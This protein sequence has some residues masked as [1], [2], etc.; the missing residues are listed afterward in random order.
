[1]RIGKQDDK[2]DSFVER[3]CVMEKL[4]SIIVPSYNMEKYLS[5]CLGSLIVEDSE[6]LQSLDVIVVNDG[7][8]DGTSEIAHE[9]ERKYPGVFRVI[10]KQNGHY[11]SCVNVGL[12]VVRGKYVKILDADDTFS[13]SALASFLSCLKTISNQGRA[14]DAV[15]TDFTIVGNSGEIIEIRKY[16]WGLCDDITLH[17]VCSLSSDLVMMH[18]ITYNSGIFG[19]LDYHQTEGIAYTD[20]EWLFAPMSKVK[21]I[22]YFPVNLYQYL[23]GREGQSVSVGATVAH[24]YQIHRTLESRLKLFSQCSSAWTKDMLAY[25]MWQIRL[26]SDGAYSAYFSAWCEDARLRLMELDVLL[27]VTCPG[28]RGTLCGELVLFPGRSFRFR[29]GRLF[30]AHASIRTWLVRLIKCYNTIRQFCW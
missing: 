17:D 9:F 22:M 15:W 29:Y 8:K 4:L 2:E 28:M 23:V 16:P 10:D 18:G 26:A 11:G 27:D 25:A 14:V 6:L 7:S 30:A 5:K 20:G 13:N 12:K 1:M 19:G 3:G 21:K 24:A